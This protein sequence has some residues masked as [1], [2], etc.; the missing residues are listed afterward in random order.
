[1]PLSQ[2]NGMSKFWLCATSRKETPAAHSA[3]APVVLL[4]ILGIKFHGI[5]DV[6]I[7]N[8]LLGERFL[9][10]HRQFV[11]VCRAV[12]F[13]VNSNV[14]FVT[15]FFRLLKS[16]NSIPW[17]IPFFRFQLVNALL[18]PLIRVDFV[19]RHTRLQNINQR[20][21][22]MLNAGLNNALQ[23]HD[24]SRIAASQKSCSAGKRNSERT[25]RH[26]ND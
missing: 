21:T 11:L 25:S 13:V 10:N 5:T 7:F 8:A 19:E 14:N 16:H 2:P 26:F 6:D 22:S 20:K 17:I 1:M 9:G 18:V 3:P 23:M 12:F 4:V 15:P 24:V